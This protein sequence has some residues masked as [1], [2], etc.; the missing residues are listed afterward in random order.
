MPRHALEHWSRLRQ[1]V[2]DDQP[3]LLLVDFDGTLAPI[4]RHADRARITESTRQLLK[5]LS[6]VGWIREGVVS[7]R[8]LPWLRK[9]VGLSGLVYVGN[10]GLEIEG[11]HA[12]FVHPL[13]R[14]YTPSL[15]RLARRL[16]RALAGVPGAWV[17]AKRLTLSV[18]WR[19]VRT[20]DI[21]AFHRRARAALAPWIATGQIQLTTGKRVLEVRPPIPWDKGKAVDWL[22][23]R[24]GG[25]VWYLGDD[26]TDEAAFR[27]AN[28]R[29]GVSIVVGRRTSTAAR[30]WLS[31]PSEV[32][33]LLRRLLDVQ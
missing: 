32:R 22:A 25:T 1:A 28:R 10:H 23:E 4:V 33:R 13:A 6:R 19:A 26:Q 18:H 11:P 8:A 24:Y 17:E 31:N 12:R 16:R 27:T 9:R 21:P 15:T 30:W 29:K 7:G 3:L 14:R 20:T 2:P 5:S